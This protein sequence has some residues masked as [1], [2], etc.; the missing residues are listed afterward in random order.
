MAGRGVMG[1]RCLRGAGGRGKAGKTWAGLDLALSVA[2]GL[3]WL[4]RFGCPIPGEVLVF[5]GEG[6]ERNAV[7]RLRA[8][9]AHKGIDDLAALPIRLCD[10]VP[11][12]AAGGE[13]A[14]IE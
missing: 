4:G 1:R 8:I 5:L 2:A 3:P 7:R 12:L 13:L 10:R 6:G 9:A 11:K 14:A